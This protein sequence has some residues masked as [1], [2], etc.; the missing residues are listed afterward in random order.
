MAGMMEKRSAKLLAFVMALIMIGS[1]MVLAFRATSRVEIRTIKFDMGSSLKSWL[2]YVP[3]DS[4]YIAYFNYSTSNETMLE[5]LYNSTVS[6]LRN[7]DPYAFY[8]IRP[9]TLDSFKRLLVA[10]PELFFIDVNRTK[11]YF[12]LKQKVNYG[13][14][15]VELGR[16][17]GRVYAFVDQI[18][19][20]VYGYPGDVLKVL[21]I[22]L[23]R[24]RSFEDVYSNY[25]S[26][27]PG[28]FNYAL[29]L[30]GKAAEKSVKSNGTP[31]A[32][33]YFVGY[34]MNGSMFEKVI[35]VHFLGNYFF[36]KTNKTEYCY[37]KNYPNGFSLAIMDDRNL[38][39][40]IN[41]TP[42]I[43]A[44]IIKIGRSRT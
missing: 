1:V 10:T 38:T 13:G 14:Y 4:E 26:K 6:L 24:N 40:L 11:V 23:G 7:L 17:I 19:P 30:S 34:R 5:F 32:D 20:V 43:R 41:T 42:E 28:S 37:C 27:I 3:A 21:N 36:V 29:I 16:F 9:N 39:K 44:I 31:V 33:F 12:A 15:T 18:H 22:V 35:G 2:K 25:T 8:I